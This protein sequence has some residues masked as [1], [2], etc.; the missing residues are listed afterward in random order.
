MTLVVL[1][2]AAVLL[3]GMGYLFAIS[4]GRPAP[5]HDA[6]GNV[7]PG[8]L[9]ERVTVAIGGIPQSMIIQS[10]DPSNPVLL[11]LHGGPGMPEFF[12]EQD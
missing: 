5:L 12:M 8:S 4:P 7:I 2:L 6:D 11:F 10:A 1:V 9:F 3:A